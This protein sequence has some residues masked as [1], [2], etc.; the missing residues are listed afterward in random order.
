MTRTENID[1]DK[2]NQ[3]KDKT[4]TEIKNRCSRVQKIKTEEA[5]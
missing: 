5:D 1:K 3:E 2:N 4:K